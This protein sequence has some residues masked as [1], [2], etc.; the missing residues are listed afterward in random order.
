M[1][2]SPR[3]I[4]AAAVAALLALGLSL[5]LQL[6]GGVVFVIVAA[7]G[8][9]WYQVQVARGRQH[10]QFFADAGEDTRLTQ[11]QG[12]SPSEM[13]VDRPTAPGRLPEDTG[14]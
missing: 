12:G 14:H 13:P 2:H 9:F 1:K 4:T 7:A 6:W 3:L 5:Y 11:L 10:D 8:Y